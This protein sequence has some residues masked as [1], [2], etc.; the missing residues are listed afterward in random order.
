MV[1]FIEVDP[2]EVEN[3]ATTHR[4]RLSYPIIKGFLETGMFLARIDM[5][6]MKQ[7][8]TSLQAS[9]TSYI[10]KHKIPVKFFQRGGQSYLMRLDIDAE[11]NQ[12]SD[13]AE[14]MI[15]EHIDA[16]EEAEITPEMITKKYMAEKDETVK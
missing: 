13:W 4:G 12:I 7:T 16:K 15:Q 11:G 1:K 14:E 10:R 8:K 5:T 9:L 3:T 2:N 6:G